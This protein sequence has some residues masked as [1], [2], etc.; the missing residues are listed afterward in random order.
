VQELEIAARGH[1]L[2]D[3]DDL[4]GHLADLDMV[5]HLRGSDV[6]HNPAGVLAAHDHI[7]DF[8]DHDYSGAWCVSGT[9]SRDGAP[10]FHP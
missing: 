8:I 4:K 2:L 1:D 9:T 7:T 3:F 6:V 5:A 10:S